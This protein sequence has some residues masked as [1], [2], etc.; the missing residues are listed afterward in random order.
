MFESAKIKEYPI[1]KKELEGFKYR[2]QDVF[3]N[4][5]NNKVELFQKYDFKKKMLKSPDLKEY[6]EENS[7]E[8]E[9][10]IKEVS[11]LKK[12]ITH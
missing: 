7:K 1:G 4:L 2:I 6:F 5:G 8:K 11:D 9:V 3:M 12:R 10:L